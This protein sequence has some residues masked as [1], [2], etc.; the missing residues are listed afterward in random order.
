MWNGRTL[1]TTIIIVLR[2]L[3]SASAVAFG[4]IAKKHHNPYANLGL[5]L[6]ILDLIFLA[7]YILFSWYLYSHLLFPPQ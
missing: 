2:V 5:F 6:G 7:Q 4:I 3:I 1:P